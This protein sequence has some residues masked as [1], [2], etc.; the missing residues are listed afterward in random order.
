MVKQ[1][2]AQ[3]GITLFLQTSVHGRRCLVSQVESAADNAQR[4]GVTRVTRVTRV[5]GLIRLLIS[6]LDIDRK[7]N[8]PEIGRGREGG[9]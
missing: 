5:T 1:R 3:V 6:C 4:A 8:Q 2:G 7:A 9:E